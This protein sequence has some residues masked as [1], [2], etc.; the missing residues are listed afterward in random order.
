MKYYSV[1]IL[2][3]LCISALKAQNI[4][5]FKKDSLQFKIYGNIKYQSNKA[6]DIKVTKVFCDYFIH[7]EQLLHLR[8][9]RTIRRWIE[10]YY[11][12]MKNLQTFCLPFDTNEC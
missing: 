5:N 4:H 2:L 3:I 8:I 9:C 10:R 6:I 11:F 1:F 12:A 7:F